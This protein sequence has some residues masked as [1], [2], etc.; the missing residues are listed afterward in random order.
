MSLNIPLLHCCKQ[1]C[2]RKQELEL[3]FRLVLKLVLRLLQFFRSIKV[4]QLFF[5]SKQVDRLVLPLF[6]LRI[7]QYTCPQ[8]LRLFCQQALQLF[9]LQV[10]QRICQL[11]LQ[12]IYQQVLKLFYLLVLLLFCPLVLKRFFQQ[13]LLRFFHNIKEQVFQRILFQVLQLFFRGFKEEALRFLQ[14]QL[15]FQQFDHG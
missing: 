13:E 14:F 2:R 3:R 9:Y 11:V 12:H 1:V 4:L 8:V 6:C 5:H 10:L 7:C 15:V